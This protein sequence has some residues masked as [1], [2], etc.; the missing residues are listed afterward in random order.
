MQA[1]GIHQSQVTGVGT[2]V[3]VVGRK[4]IAKLPQ[5]VSLAFPAASRLTPP[6]PNAML[7]HL[8][9]TTLLVLHRLVAFCS[10]DWCAIVAWTRE[11]PSS[12]KMH[13]FFDFSGCCL[14]WI[15][16]YLA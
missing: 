13:E 7:A 2:T 16:I 9:I 3:Q 15:N 14:L 12:Q 8:M 10:G 11:H 5:L 6:T 4:S 1:F